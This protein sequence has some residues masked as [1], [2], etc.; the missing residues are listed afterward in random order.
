MINN[1]NPKKIIKSLCDE[2][3]RHNKLY[4]ID[5]KPQISDRDFDSLMTK[6]EALESKFPQFKLKSSPTQRIGGEPLNEFN[7]IKHS[8]P[9]QSLSNTYN[10]DELIKFDER[11]KKLINDSECDYIIEPKIDGVAI[12]IRY[13]NGYLIHA[14]TRGDGITGDDVTENIK[15]IKSIPLKLLGSNPPSILEVR[16]EIFLN[17]NKF[18]DLNKKRIRESKDPFANPRN[19]CAGSLKLL[20]PKEVSTRP[21]D[22]IFYNLGEHTINEIGTHHKLLEKLKNYGIKVSPYYKKIRRFDLLLQNLDELQNLSKEFPF[23]IDGAVIKVN[24]LSLHSV[25]GE[26]SK[27]PRW[28]VAYKYESEQAVTQLNAITIQVGRTGVLTPVAE[29]E[30]VQLAGTIV[31]RATLHNYDEIIRKDIR[32]GDHII[33]EKAGEIIPIVV[34]VIFEKRALNSKKF[35]FPEFPC[36][37]CILPVQKN[38][39]EVAIRCINVNCPSKLKNWITHFASRKALDISGLGE[40]VVEQLV[41][42]KLIQSPSDIYNLKFSD[43]VNLERFGKKSAENLLNSIKDSKKIS[44]GRVLYALGIPH[45]GKT[46]SETIANYY[47]N[48]DNIFLTTIEELEEIDDVGPIV[49]KSIKAYFSNPEYQL[50]IQRLK[51]YGVKFEIESVQSDETLKGQTFVFTGTLPNLSR[52][53]ASEKIELRGGKISSN[54]SKKTNYLIAG[55]ASGSK[56]EKAKNLGIKVLN[57][58]EFMKLIKN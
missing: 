19:A 56:L 14:A 40:S 53:E 50:V 1:D 17:K 28:A 54:I 23:E 7:N 15:T 33:I 25:L 36:S 4:Y 29:L 18:E 46:A 58:V 39:N 5:A 35:E 48:I 47:Q 41:K 12:S 27:S 30:P 37:E 42:N 38:D 21:L 31:K 11:V 9:M 55:K 49:A 43:L 10:K 8:I 20:D 24:E 6:L 16:G 2:I 57:E 45:V 3:N 22:A 34:K 51:N 26:T 13:E 52:N 32:V 44:F